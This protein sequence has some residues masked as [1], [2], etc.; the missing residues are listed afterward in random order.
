METV[1]THGHPP[2]RVAVIHGGPGAPGSMASVAQELSPEGG[3]LEP[4]QTQETVWGQLEELQEMMESHAS[5]PVVLVGHSY[6]AWLSFLMAARYPEG[7]EKVILVGS[8]PFTSEYVPLMN[9]E[10]NGRLTAQE[11]KQQESFF[12]SRAGPGIEW[13]QGFQEFG[14]VMSQVDS[15]SPITQHQEDLP[16]RLDLFWKNMEE[17]NELR[18]GGHLLAWGSRIEAPVLVLHG[19]YDS[20][21][22]QGVLLP[23]YDVVKDFRFILLPRCGHVPWNE[24]YAREAFFALLK[25][26]LF[27]EGP[28]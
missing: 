12:A 26:E 6:G 15:Y 18:E 19:E 27:G 17:M 7:I 5:P 8:G 3:I 25:K 11:K 22:F 28:G 16:Y 1:R 4:F 20:H 14:R 23:L 9:R 21:P 10:R 13:E 2:Y 24:R